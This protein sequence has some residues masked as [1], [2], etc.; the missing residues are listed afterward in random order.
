MSTCIW[1]PII[2]HSY[3][4][5]KIFNFLDSMIENRRQMNI[6]TKREMRMNLVTSTHGYNVIRNAILK[7]TYIDN[8]VSVDQPHDSGFRMSSYPAAESGP[9][10]FLY[11]ARFRFA[12]EDWCR[13]WFAFINGLIRNSKNVIIQ[14]QCHRMILKLYSHLPRGFHLPDFLNTLHVFGK[15]RIIDN[16]RFACSLDKR[17]CLV[18]AVKVGCSA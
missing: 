11:S 8:G 13:S 3:K 4:M 17:S 1:I 2:E 7:K 18:H 16:S 10:P 14:M 12:H 9:F 5:K 15:L 6:S